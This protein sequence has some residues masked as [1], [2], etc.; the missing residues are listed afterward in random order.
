MLKREIFVPIV[1]RLGLRNQ[2]AQGARLSDPFGLAAER[3]GTHHPD[4]NIRSVWGASSRAP[5]TPQVTTRRT[6]RA[7]GQIP[8]S[9]LENPV[10]DCEG[11]LAKDRQAS[12]VTTHRPRHSGHLSAYDDVGESTTRRATLPRCNG[13]QDSRA[14][15]NVYAATFV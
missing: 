4:A 8:K 7:S 14:A 13:L 3:R 5:S 6:G 1:C 15:V 10:Q 2:A 11:E 9:L 12:W